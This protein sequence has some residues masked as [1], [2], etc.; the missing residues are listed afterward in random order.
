MGSRVAVAE[1][2][3]NP[4]A[5]SNSATGRLERVFTDAEFESK[6]AKAVAAA[7]TRR[8]GVRVQEEGV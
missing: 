4:P 8:A 6:K 2:N 1:S 7:T 5:P 3:L